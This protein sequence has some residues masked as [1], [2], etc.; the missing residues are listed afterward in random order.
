MKV[1]MDSPPVFSTA[2]KS[3]SVSLYADAEHLRTDILSS[4]G[5][6]LGL[7]LIKLTGIHLL[8]PI[9]AIIVALVIFRAGF[10]ISKS[11]M[12]N[13]LDCS[14]PESDL[15][16]IDDILDTFKAQGIVGYKDLRARRLGPQKS[17]TLTLI[18]PKDMTIF[19]CHTICDS[20]ERE[21]KNRLGDVTSSIHLEPD[22][23]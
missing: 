14:L 9:V 5:V 1:N 13:L 16:A 10:S 4:V 22:K 2:L 21:L 11:T 3:E 8:D 17:I 23:F 19:N 15:K 6:F 20:V 12:N 18:F 7:L